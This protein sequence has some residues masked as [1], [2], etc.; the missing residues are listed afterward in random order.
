MAA[1]VAGNAD[2]HIGTK[3]GAGIAG[4]AAG[5]TIIIDAYALT[6]P[7]LARLPAKKRFGGGW[8]ALSDADPRSR[9][10]VAAPTLRAAGGG[11][12]VSP[13]HVAEAGCAGALR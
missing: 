7:L 2:L 10:R 13:R 5:R 12:D 6:D 9:W 8:G 1:G 4:I 3:P 11:G